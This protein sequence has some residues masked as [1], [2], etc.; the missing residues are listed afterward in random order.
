HAFLG[1]QAPTGRIERVPMMRGRIVAL[2]GTPAER[3]R[4]PEDAAWVLDGDRGITYAA[5]MPEGSTLVEGRWWGA[6][7]RESLVSF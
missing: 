1:G 7:E 5:D 4:P 6:D 2:N 3:I